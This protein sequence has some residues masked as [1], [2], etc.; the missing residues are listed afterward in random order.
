MSNR[1]PSDHSSEASSPHL[2]VIENHE[3]TR[4]FVRYVLKDTY[5]LTVV[6]SAHDALEMARDEA[7]DGVLLDIALQSPHDGMDVMHALRECEAY[8][9]TP[10]VAMTAYAMPGDQERFLK[11]GFD[12]YISKPFMRADIHAVLEPFFQQERAS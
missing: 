8:A 7:Y 6:A 3:P 5:R 4:M 10:I 9:N 2:L 11:A 12:A 1:A